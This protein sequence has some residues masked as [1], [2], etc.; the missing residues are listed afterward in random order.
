MTC[1]HHLNNTVNILESTS[2]RYPAELQYNWTQSNIISALLA[3]DFVKTKYHLAQ[4]KY[5]VVVDAAEKEGE[6]PTVSLTSNRN[7]R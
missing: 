2:S 7:L 5:R 6:Q 3:W 4:I 1:V